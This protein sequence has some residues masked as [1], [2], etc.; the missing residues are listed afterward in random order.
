MRAIKSLSLE[1]ALGAVCYQVFLF[2]LSFHYYPALF[3]TAILGLTVWIIYLLDRQ[4]DNQVFSPAD[5]RHL[6]HVQFRKPIRFLILLLSL[7]VIF[8]LSKLEKEILWAGCGLS[9]LVLGY[10]FAAFKG[11]LEVEKELLTS[12]LYGLGVGISVWARKPSAFW[13][14]LPLIALAYQN[15]CFFALLESESPFYRKRL[16]VTEWICFGL[17]LGLMGSLTDLFIV[18]PFLV[19]FGITIILTRLPFSEDK[20]FV[21]DLAFWS[22]LIY[23]LHGIFST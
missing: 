21:A 12:I 3:E 6:F 16:R 7:L 5:D 15:L 2:Q 8:L 19:T 17:I 20:R 9:L 10:W 14:I 1:V 4:F 22:P 11:W 13:F 23:L 18:L